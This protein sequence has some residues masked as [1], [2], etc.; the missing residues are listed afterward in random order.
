M[1]HGY[2]AGRGEEWGTPRTCLPSSEDESQTRLDQKPGRAIGGGGEAGQ[3]A[4]RWMDGWSTRVDP[5]PGHACTS[6][7]IYEPTVFARLLSDL[8]VHLTPSFSRIWGLVVKPV[9]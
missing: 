2:A 1:G 9:G 7:L 5:P 3:E 4:G 8:R 6:T